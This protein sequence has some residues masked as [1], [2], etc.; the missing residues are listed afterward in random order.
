MK[1]DQNTRANHSNLGNV[2]ILNRVRLVAIFAQIILI[3]FAI[4]YLEIKLPLIYISSFI[5]AEILFWFYSANLVR[6]KRSISAFELFG[7]IVFDSLIVAGLIYYTGG[8]NNPFIYILL[9]SVA[10]SSFMLPPKYLVLITILEL[11]LYSIL[12]LY[13]HPMELGDTSP[14]ASFHLHMAGMWVN[15]IIT[16]I[17]IAIFGLLTRRTMLRQEKKLQAL[18]EKQVQDEQI[19]GLGIMSASAAHELGTPLS[20]MAIIVDDL[21]HTN[22]DELKD[23]MKLLSQQIKKC[24]NI[25]AILNDKSQTAKRQLAVQEGELNQEHDFNLVQRFKTIAENWMVYRP[26]IKFDYTI[27]EKIA[28]KSLSVSISL[29]QAISNLLDNAADASLE[30]ASDL[31]ELAIYLKDGKDVVIDIKDS[32]IGTSIEARRTLGTKIQ[33]TKKKNGLGW[34]VFLSNVSIERAGGSV[35]LLESE[36]GGTLTRIVFTGD[37]L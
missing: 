9:L 1:S 8:A 36:N 34:G 7:H 26:K 25:I 23:D 13:Q 27:D 29:E 6:K 28:T 4:L 15:F 30:N 11:A 12:N 3:T 14:L 10:L 16:V 5:F 19:L 20:T 37:K 24:K 35:Q 17:L 32:G 18:R 31:V 2:I 33:E 21:T 22:N